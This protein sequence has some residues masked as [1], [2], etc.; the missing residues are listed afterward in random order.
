M[1]DLYLKRSADAMDRNATQNLS[2]QTTYE[3][4]C[5]MDES[6]M[7]DSDDMA[8]VYKVDEV[9]VSTLSNDLPHPKNI[10]YLLSSV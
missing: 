2:E 7:S 6:Q 10:I 5:G 1:C 9:H 4:V 3:D 8:V